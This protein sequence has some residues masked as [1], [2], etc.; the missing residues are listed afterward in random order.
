MRA[1]GQHVPTL[2]NR[3][4]QLPQNTELATIP[5]PSPHEEW[6]DVVIT[7]KAGAFALPLLYFQI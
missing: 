5:A 1:V 6:N 7:G 4:S 3:P 2:C